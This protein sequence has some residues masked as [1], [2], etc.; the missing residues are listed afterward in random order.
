MRIHVVGTSGSGKTTVARSAAARLGVPHLELDAV[1]HQ[2]NWTEMPNDEMWAVVTAFTTQHEA[3]VVD[4][5]YGFVR[6]AL[7]ARATHIV[8]LDLPRWRIMTQ[9]IRRS[10]ARAAFRRELWNGNTETFR[11]WADPTHPIRWAWTS[12]DRR[13][14]QYAESVATDPR[15]V[16]LTSRREVQ[17]WLGSLA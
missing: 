13:R 6:D 12:R 14:Q 8:F 7:W 3:W 2:P 15:W 9:V 10:F 5:N 17:A 1:R 11:S 16:V 4:G